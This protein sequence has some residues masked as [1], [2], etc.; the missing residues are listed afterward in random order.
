M[1]LWIRIDASIGTDP[2]TWD[3]ADSCGVSAESAVGHL[4][5][6]YG[7]MAEHCKDGSL[8][9]VSVLL[10]ER[11][12]GW[13]GEAGRFASAFAQLY[14]TSGQVT[15]WLAQQGK[16]LERAERER[17]RWHRRNSAE[18]LPKLRGD[19]V[20]TPAVRNGTERNGTIKEEE[21]A[22]SPVI[23]L[24]T[25]YTTDLSELLDRVGRTPNASAT[26]W[27]HEIA[28]AIEGMHGKPVTPAVLGQSIRDFNASGA[29]I[30]L[31]LFRG[32]LRGN[33][34]SGPATAAESKPGGKAYASSGWRGGKTL[35][36]TELVQ[37]VRK[38]AQPNPYS[39]SLNMVHGWEL[40]FD[41]TE[42]RVLKAFGP[43]RCLNDGNEGTLISQ[44]AK[45]LEEAAG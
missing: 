16:L 44:L 4:V 42:I 5:M 23:D 26:A 18:T 24:P 31:R 8:V 9:N 6:L 22:P 40:G 13:H 17:E 2:R 36:A 11:W 41:E 37:R 14:V 43:S 33:G 30:S 34:A 21:E 29:E 19:S 39:G 15:A 32:Y 35:A 25:D 28:A 38:A 45:A 1:N 27:R 10:L 20:E 7:A 3:L 12:A